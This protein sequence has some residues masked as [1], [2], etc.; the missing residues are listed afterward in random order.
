MALDLIKYWQY[1][2]LVD[3]T[4][5]TAEQNTA[6]EL[7]AFTA[8]KMNE[9][10]GVIN[11]MS[12]DLIPSVL[13]DVENTD[14]SV[15]G[16]A[17]Y[18]NG[19]LDKWENR[20]IDNELQYVY[21]AQFGAIGDGV[22]DDTIAVQAAI[23][24]C[25]DNKLAL[26]LNMIYKISKIVFDLKYVFTLISDGG[27]LLG[28][29]AGD[30]TC[31][32]EV[33]DC[34]FLRIIGSL[35]INGSFNKGYDCGV[36]IRHN[37]AG[38]SFIFITGVYITC[39][40][41]SFIIGDTDHPDSPMSE[42]LFDKISSIGNPIFLEIIGAQAAV[43]VRGSFI[44][45]DT[46]FVDEAWAALPLAIVKSYGALVR[47]NDCDL[48]NLFEAASPSFILMPITSVA[49]NNPFGNIYCTNCIIES[50]SQLA[51]IY[52]PDNVTAPTNGMVDISTCNG[53]H[54]FDLAD[55]IYA[56]VGYTGMIRVR[57]CNFYC[58]VARVTFYNIKAEEVTCRIWCDDKSF[59]NN[60][61]QGI[62]GISGGSPND[63]TYA[64]NIDRETLA[65]GVIIERNGKNR[66][67]HFVAAAS[68]G[69]N[70]IGGLGLAAGDNPAQN[71]V[72][73]CSY[74]GTTM[75]KIF[76]LAHGSVILTDIAE[77][78]QA[79]KTNIIGQITWEV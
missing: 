73:I 52:N 75:G 58:G 12:S 19:R 3:Q 20:I 49:S 36:W 13:T 4:I 72:C 54:A 18:L 60:F 48:L 77:A 40:R 21:P 15:E 1:P 10:I 24:Y 56:D 16:S 76:V 43:T 78:G 69:A 39:L 47:F 37:T 70:L 55:Y 27:K 6:L 44:T 29:A 34:Q 28:L 62:A 53:Y 65:S 9:V 66:I 71:I 7:A 68:D 22:T 25:Y 41:K 63:N 31:M 42:I 45:L 51:L 38:S 61:K 26:K 67:M 11:D 35:E 30:Y 50:A 79:S 23:E 59:G 64:Y 8:Y 17:T 46:R 2:E 14:F 57:D 5:K 32:L 33:I 74:S